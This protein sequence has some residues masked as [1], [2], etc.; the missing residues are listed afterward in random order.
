M[1]KIAL[2][3]IEIFARHGAFKTEK[4]IRQKFLVSVFFDFDFEE[5]AKEDDLFK[6][7]DY[8]EII[9]LVKETFKKPCS[10]IEKLAYDTANKIK[11][12]FPEIQNIVVKVSKPEVQLGCN[13]KKVEVSYE[14]K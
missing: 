14:L 12:T 10:L 4:K 1:G 3:N 9:G 6:T 5:A 11:K 8:S 13:L 2:E 7:I